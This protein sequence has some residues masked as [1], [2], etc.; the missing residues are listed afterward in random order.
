MDLPYA[1]GLG[2]WQSLTALPRQSCPGP[3]RLRPWGTSGPGVRPPWAGRRRQ[4]SRALASGRRGA[5]GSRSCPRSRRRAARTPTPARRRE[6]PRERRPAPSPLT[7]L[8]RRPSP[9]LPLRAAG[10]AEQRRRGRAG[11]GRAGRA[12]Q[13]RPHRPAARLPGAPRPPP[14]PLPAPGSV[15]GTGTLR[16][17]WGLELEQPSGRA[18]NL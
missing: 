17:L 15:R 8:P 1:E 2:S 12:G 7:A 3:A 18:G 13:G 4:Y 9:L 14:P 10:P 5:P 16:W 6:Q 11:Q